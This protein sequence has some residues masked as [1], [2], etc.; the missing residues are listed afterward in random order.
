MTGT[1]V[2]AIAIRNVDLSNFRNYPRLHIETGPG[3]IVLTGANGSG[4]TNL[5][6]A[7]SMFMP[8]RGMRG[9][10]FEA[11]LFKQADTAQWAVSVSLDRPDEPLRM[12][13]SWQ[14]TV[15][16]SG[17]T[18]QAN[19]DRQAAKGVGAFGN[20]IRLI[21]LTPSMDRLFSGSAGDRRRFLDRIVAA[22]DPGHRRMLNSFEKLMRQRN[23]MLAEGRYDAAWLSILEQQMAEQAIAIAATRLAAI[24]VLQ[25]HIDET[26]ET[27]GRSVFPAARLML[28][29]DIEA[30]LRHTPAVQSEDEYAKMLCDSR[31]IDQAAGRTLNGPHRSDLLVFH[32]AKKM[33]ARACSTG[34]QKALLIGLILAQAKMVQ[35]AFGGQMPVLLLDE[36]AA[37]LDV[38]RRKGL[39]EELIRSG[40]QC[41]LT[42]TDK[43]QFEALQDRAQFFTVTDGMIEKS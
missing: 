32:S 18:R 19:I 17:Q 21:W 27:G 5:L 26:P 29:G 4:K 9:N 35:S 16:G 33:E 41:W 22:S 23:V 39:F 6:E 25:E 2:P 13:T 36:I 1:G 8:G 42:G 31:K 10:S 28:T 40:A 24:D 12:G 43:M 14:Q 7:I 38:D 20:H 11:M 30:S 37:H 34:E 3:P 15:N